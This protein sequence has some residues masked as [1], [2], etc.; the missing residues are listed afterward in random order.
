MDDLIVV[1]GTAV[2]R[3]SADRATLTITARVKQP[4]A[5]DAERALAELT[6]AV[7]AVLDDFSAVVTSRRT[8]HF[9]IRPNTY[10]HAPSGANVV[11]G[12]IGE[13]GIRITVADMG[14]AG[15]L[16]RV[17]YDAAGVEVNGP[18]GK[19]PTT[20]RCTDKPGEPPPA[21]LG[22]A[23]SSTQR[24]SGSRSAALPS[25]ASRDCGASHRA[26]PERWRSWPTPRWKPNRSS[27]LVRP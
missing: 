7:D 25:S 8:E 1:R 23:P 14:R 26:W 10:W 18:E 6:S 4:T 12:Q 22:S 16:I 9:S 5:A 20:T 2:S 17:L 13:R 19:S 21:T 27:I 3:I 15:A 24:V 11:D